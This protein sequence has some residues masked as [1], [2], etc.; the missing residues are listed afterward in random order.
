[1][2][3]NHW[4][5]TNLGEHKATEE[6][7]TNMVE[8]VDSMVEKYFGRT[9]RIIIEVPSAKAEPSVEC[10]LRIRRALESSRDQFPSDIQ[11]I[12]DEMIGLVNETLYLLTLK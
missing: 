7:Y 1:M 8:L 12:M 2:H 5:T 4:K 11:N 3:L 10:M 9:K 6:Y